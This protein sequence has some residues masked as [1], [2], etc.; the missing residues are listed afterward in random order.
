[1][2]RR[3][4]PTSSLA[5]LALIACAPRGDA[6][7]P[8]GFRVVFPDA[9]TD[10]PATFSIRRGVHV[11]LKPTAQCRYAD[12][13]DA[14]WTMTGARVAHGEL[15]PGLTLEDGAIVGVAQQVGAWQ[16][17]VAFAG[18]T[19]AG[20]RLPDVAVAISITVH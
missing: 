3:L 18:V 11:Q 1:M 7:D 19:C 12:G 20:R 14:R 9:R 2:P 5:L 15:P 6:G 4:S 17:S 8:S 13:K 16:A 10:D